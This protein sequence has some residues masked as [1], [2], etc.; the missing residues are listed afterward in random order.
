ML[1]QSTVLAKSG[2][3]RGFTAIIALGVVCSIP[4]IVTAQTPPPP[5]VH[6]VTKKVVH[7]HKRHVERH[8]LAKKAAN[9]KSATVAIR[10]ISRA[11]RA[12]IIGITPSGTQVRVWNVPPTSNPFTAAGGV[13]M[14]VG[15]VNPG[16]VPAARAPF[17]TTRALPTG[18]VLAPARP[19]VSILPPQPTMFAGG[20]V[21][22]AND[23]AS[24]LAISRGGNIVTVDMNNTDIVTA[25]RAAFKAAGVNFTIKSTVLHTKVTCTLTN[26]EIT[27]AV[28][29]ILESSSQELTYRIDGGVYVILPGSAER[30]D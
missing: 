3:R 6:K 5:A 24:P 28:R 18:T 17:A 4:W 25:L 12:A 19:A 7:P 2:V 20:L 11:P 9:V 15:V 21:P 1:N 23:E 29:A 10:A 27:T 13:K 16:M 14:P 22:P 26:V 8:H 30:A